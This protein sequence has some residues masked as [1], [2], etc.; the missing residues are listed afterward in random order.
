MTR[1]ERQDL[2]V[3][4][5][6]AAGHN[7][8]VEAFTGF[9][10]TRIA[11]KAI[12]RMRR[13]DRTRTVVVIVPKIVLKEQWEAELTKMGLMENTRILVV[14]SAAMM[15]ELL[16]CSLLII[17]EIHRTASDIFR[18]IFEKIRARWRLGLTARL[19]RLDGKHEIIVKI[20][21]VCDIVTMQEG[22]FSG[23]T[24][25]FTEYNLGIDMTP[26]EL[27]W[28]TALEENYENYLG[29]FK[30]D[31]G[32]MMKCLDPPIPVVSTAGELTVILSPPVVLLAREYGWEG[33]SARDA[34]QNIAYN[35]TVSKNQRVSVWGNYNHDF[36]PDKLKIWAINGMRCIRSLKD[37]IFHYPAKVTVGVE[38]INKLNR[39]TIAFCEVTKVSDDL[40]SK[41]GEQAVVYHTKVTSE[42][43]S[44]KKALRRALNSI[45]TGEKKFLV[46]AKAL[47]EG[48]DWPEAEAGIDLNRT[49]NPLQ[50]TQRKGRPGR[51]LTFA[52]GTQKLSLYVNV[53]LRRTLDKKW[54]SKAQEKGRG[55][56]II[57][58]DTIDE[59]IEAESERVVS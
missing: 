46:S 7:G 39:K 43:I 57:E 11:A 10:K 30:K 33:N 14:N 6:E 53:Y 25:P 15:K 8:T 36:S 2:A 47:D 21:P 29:K 28:Y 27:A 31:F 5:W 42:G 48:L 22:K 54:L 13:T 50:H 49:S 35:K 52:D 19:S 34:L 41:L 20:V 44:K 32:L 9:G 59:I 51:K 40:A 16:H 58:V 12:N 45:L 17:D 3:S 38:L 18:L 4:R 1:D 24:S 26:K 23:W 55:Q 37:F 56:T